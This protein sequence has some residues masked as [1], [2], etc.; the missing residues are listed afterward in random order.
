MQSQ[1]GN[2]FPD[3]VKDSRMTKGSAE[4]VILMVL[5]LYQSE[6]VGATYFLF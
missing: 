1:M 5:I 2:G 4:A 6:D 3:V